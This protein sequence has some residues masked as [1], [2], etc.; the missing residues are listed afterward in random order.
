MMHVVVSGSICGTMRVGQRLDTGRQGHSGAKSFNVVMV[1]EPKAGSTARTGQRTHSS[2][3]QL[4]QGGHTNPTVM[5]P[6]NQE[7][8]VRRAKQNSQMVNLVAGANT[9]ANRR[10]LTTAAIILGT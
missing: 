2:T 9:M 3:V 1:T 7:M 4:F 10:R 8:K 5:L 6:I